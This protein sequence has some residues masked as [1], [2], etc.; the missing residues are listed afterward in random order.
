MNLNRDSRGRRGT[1]WYFSRQ[2]VSCAKNEM[3]QSPKKV[4]NFFHP[5]LTKLGYPLDMYL[6]TNH[7][8]KNLNRTRGSG[9]MAW[10]FKGLEIIQK[11]GKIP[12]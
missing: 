9:D 1:Q 2:I 11:R 8:K 3:L 4:Q 5:N 10:G 7:A 6:R 12:L